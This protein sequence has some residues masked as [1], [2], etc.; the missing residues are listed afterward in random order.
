MD[1]AKQLYKMFKQLKIDNDWF[2]GWLFMKTN[3]TKQ[4]VVKTARF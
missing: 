1:K 4:K 3:Y 2:N